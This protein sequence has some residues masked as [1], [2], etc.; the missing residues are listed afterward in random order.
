MDELLPL[1]EK[2]RDIPAI[3]EGKKDVRAL[4]LLGF[5]NVHKLDRPL[6]E[7]FERFE[8]GDVVQI[9]TDFDK[10][11][12]ELYGRIKQG[13]ARHGVRIDDTLRNALWKTK[14]SHVEG[15]MTY[16]KNYSEQ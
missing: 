16:I 12:K 14:I 10:K 1:L 15:L 13:L 5:S 8:R 6:Y 9:L 3:V 11:G 2:K 7:V 4:E